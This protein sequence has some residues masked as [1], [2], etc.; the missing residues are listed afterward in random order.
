MR[1]ALL[2]LGLSLPGLMLLAYV[3]NTAPDPTELATRAD[4]EVERR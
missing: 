1:Y 4:W 2:V 3:L